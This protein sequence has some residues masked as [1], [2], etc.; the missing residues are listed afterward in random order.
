MLRGQL[1]PWNFSYI[2]LVKHA[3]YV[4]L[5]QPDQD[6]K[7]LN[8]NTVDISGNQKEAEPSA[9]PAC[10][11]QPVSV[12]EARMSADRSPS[13]QVAS[14]VQSAVQHIVRGTEAS[15]NVTH[16]SSNA[17]EYL[18]SS[19]TQVF[20]AS[21]SHQHHA[22]LF[23]DS[24]A[25]GDTFFGSDVNLPHSV[26]KFTDQATPKTAETSGCE[27]AEMDPESF[28]HVV[29]PLFRLCLWLKVCSSLDLL[30][31]LFI[32]VHANYHSF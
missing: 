8:D 17:A 9:N 26:A 14:V 31:C 13:Q 5:L 20:T 22:I 21:S 2:E 15:E 29:N 7:P 32:N 19:N 3:A 24:A 23:P 10:H 16:C 6:A 11:P 28:L 30:P 27:A 18:A 4:D 25:H 1:L 12:N